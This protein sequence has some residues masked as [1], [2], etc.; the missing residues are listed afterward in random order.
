MAADSSGTLGIIAGGGALPRSLIAAAQARG[1]AVFVIA[2]NGQ[3]DPET[4]EGVPHRWCRLGAS[5]QLFT[6]LKQHQVSQLVMAG[7]IRRPGWFE[8]RPD[9]FGIG[10]LARLRRL[11]PIGDDGLLRNLGKIFEEYGIEMIGAHEVA[12]D[13]LASAG[14]IGSRQP[15]AAQLQSMARGRAIL[16]AI[17]PFDLGQAIVVQ[18]DIVLGMEAVEGTDG[19]IRRTAALARQKAGKP[20]LVKMAKPQQDMRFDVP[21]IGQQ[22][23]REVAAAGFAG[24]AVEAGRTILLDAE[25]LPA[26]ADELGIFLIAQAPDA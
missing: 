5:R 2:F 1:R 17:G 15:N 25:I 16:Q 12:T 24:I 26:L 21:T 22:T 13:L 14:T 19:L 8:L 4:T 6:A 18:D 9:L 20:I 23:L 3:T 11:G 7:A 10:L